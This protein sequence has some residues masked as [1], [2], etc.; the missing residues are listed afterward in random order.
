M[1]INQNTIQE[2]IYS[3]IDSIGWHVIK[4]P[5]DFEGPGFAY[6]VGL[7]KSYNHP[8]LI[9]FGLPIEVMHKILN[10]ICSLIQ[11]GEEMKSDSIRDGVLKSGIHIKFKT[12]SEEKLKD[13]VIQMKLFYQKNIPT[14]QVLWPDKLNKL[15]DDDLCDAIVKNKQPRLYL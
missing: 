7:F 13:Y 1:S 12:A 10:N 9:I 3:D 11:S 8:E 15:S 5:E 2:K 4:V 14:L 6:T